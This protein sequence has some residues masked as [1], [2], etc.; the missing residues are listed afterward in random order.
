VPPDLDC[1]FYVSRAPE[2]TFSE[3]M[4][5]ISYEIGREARFEIVLSPHTFL[6]TRRR[7]AAAEA[8]FHAH[9][10]IVHAGH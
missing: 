8:E 7:A 10:K 2:I 3:G 9:G 6:L 4:F 5:H 1:V